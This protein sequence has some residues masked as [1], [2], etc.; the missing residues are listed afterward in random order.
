[1]PALVNGSHS[2]NVDLL[3][4]VMQGSIL[5]RLLFVLFTADMSSVVSNNMFIY[6]DDCTLLAVVCSLSS[7]HVMADICQIWSML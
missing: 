1:M 4:G 5:V 6:D 3:L 2:L 7:R